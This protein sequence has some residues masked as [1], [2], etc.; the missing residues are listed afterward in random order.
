LDAVNLFQIGVASV[1]FTLEAVGCSTDIF[2]RQDAED[3]PRHKS[4]QSL[5]VWL[6][7]SISIDS[8]YYFYRAFYFEKDSRV[9][10]D[11]LNLF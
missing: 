4:G 9:S 8:D 10:N 7:V 11:G 5:D 2:S 6:I 1:S 3:N